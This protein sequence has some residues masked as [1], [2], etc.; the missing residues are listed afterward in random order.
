MRLRLLQYLILQPPSP[1]TQQTL[2]YAK[3]LAFIATIAS[4]AVSAVSA[5]PIV[6]QYRDD[7]QPCATN[8]IANFTLA[9]WNTNIMMPNANS[10]GVP[11]VL[12]FGSAIEG[13]EWYATSVSISS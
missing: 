7:S 13:A 6:L 2:V 8:S 11:L 5:T 3:M 1:P 4:L 10:T 12:G 9:A